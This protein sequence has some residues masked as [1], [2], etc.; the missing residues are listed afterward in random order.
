MHERHD[1]DLV[2]ALAQGT[3]ED[4]APGRE[5]VDSCPE[6]AEY[7]EANLLVLEAI[8]SEP[9]PR[10]TD[11]E[12]FR[13][14]Q[15]VW[16][17]VDSAEPETTPEVPVASSTPRWYR[18]MGAAAILAAF[19]A[20]G[21]VLVGGRGGETTLT[22]AA[23][24]VFSRLQPSFRPK[25]DTAEPFSGGGEDSSGSNTTP[26]AAD[27]AMTEAAADD[28]A[29]DA[30]AQSLGAFAAADLPEMI[31]PVHRPA[32]SPEQQEPTARSSAEIGSMPPMWWPPK[33]PR[34]TAFQCGSWR[35]GT[36]TT[37]PCRCSM[38]RTARSSTRQGE[39]PRRG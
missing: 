1:L 6:C 2:F 12:R 36:Q 14:R 31:A 18:I 23:R 17:E 9:A 8:R 7:Y 25:R 13:L 37:R 19:V 32:S 29:A 28:G 34:W 16:A 20:V 35:L 4:P 33:E 5:L 10:L 22:T 15:A 27:T 30:Q 26:A 24:E 3:L 11:L 39:R 38:P 21:A